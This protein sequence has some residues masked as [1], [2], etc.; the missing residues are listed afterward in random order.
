[1][2]LD[3][4]GNWF[5]DLLKGAIGD[6]RAALHEPSFDE[7]DKEL[8]SSCIESGFVSSVGAFVS[9]FEE[10][11]KAA[12][13]SKHAIAVSSGTAALHISLLLA[14][15]KSNDE[16]LVPTISFVATAN[17]VVHANAVPHFVDSDPN[18]L[19]MSPAALRKVLSRL[20]SRDGHLTN[21]QTGRRV[22]AIVPMHTF[23]HPVNMVEII[24]ISLEFGIP[25]VEDSAESLG[26][27]VSGRHTGTLGK[28]GILSFNGNKIIT[29]GGG[30]AI[31]TQDDELA[32]KA[33]SLTTTAKTPHPWRFFHDS[34]AWNYRL[35]N[36]N[37]ALGV[38][39]LRKLPK[40]LELKRD[41]ASIYL[42]TFSKVEG[43]SVITEPKDS[44]SNY[45]LNAVKLTRPDRGMIEKI[46]EITNREG[47]GTRPLW[48]PLHSLPMFKKAPRGDLS[49]ALSL[50]D[51][52]IA[53]P[54]S[55]FLAARASG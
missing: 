14:G 5:L 33:R 32:D 1:M 21:E 31:L 24:Q 26:S 2:I 38:A 8:V 18:T 9:V 20:K 6:E 46:L 3:D 19:G 52:V 34:V 28:L 51:S 42:E 12:T 39:Q 44:L 25:I 23:G 43:L 27:F 11:L 17:S 7:Q 29:T 41:L 22:A 4:E 54:S 13:G 35:P 40:F 30:G 15:V 16:V 49:V 37:A 53:L 47:F 36:L 10:E 50:S 45:W 48:E 55:P